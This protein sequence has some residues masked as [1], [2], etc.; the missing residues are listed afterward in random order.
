M[1]KW[2]VNQLG[3]T[4]ITFSTVY[5]ILFGH[6]ITS[7]KDSQCFI[8]ELT[9]LT[10][11]EIV[12]TITNNVPLLSLVFSFF[13]IIIYMGLLKA[14]PASCF[15]ENAATVPD[16]CEVRFASASSSLQLSGA[17]GSIY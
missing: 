5:C 6:E 1:A 12:N 10:I 13:V 9:H 4:F 2:R 7:V 15:V 17:T 14:Q 8:V 11:M 16:V 3:S